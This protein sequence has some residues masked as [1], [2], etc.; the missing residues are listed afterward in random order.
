MKNDERDAL[1]LYEI[2]TKKL[3][4]LTTDKNVDEQDAV[5]SPDGAWIAFVSNHGRRPGQDRK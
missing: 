3:E 5:W 1:Y 4:K 2:A